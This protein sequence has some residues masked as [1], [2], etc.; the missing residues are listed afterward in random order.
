MYP[1]IPLTPTWGNTE[2]EQAD[3]AKTKYGEAGIEQRDFIG[4]N[5]I[6][7]SWDINVNILNFQEVDDFLK[8]RRGRPFRLSLDGG[9]ADDGKI[10]I[11]KE[12]NIQQQG[13]RTAAFSGK[14]EQVRRY[15]DEYFLIYTFAG[16][17]KNL[18]ISPTDTIEIGQRYPGHQPNYDP[19]GY[20]ISFYSPNNGTGAS[21]VVYEYYI[22]SYNGYY[23]DAIY[24]RRCGYSDFASAGID[25]GG[26]TLVKDTSVRCGSP[27]STTPE[28]FIKVIRNNSVFFEDSGDCPVTYS[29]HN[30]DNF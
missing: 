23:Y 10:Y 8:T 20:Q 12:W 15:L 17:K 24:F 26:T 13:D 16:I 28:C 2:Q 7:T 27:E 4:I 11:C 3:V 18:D 30:G 1:I 29:I 6:T 22:E 9:V 5:P 19:L 21:F 14:F 25:P